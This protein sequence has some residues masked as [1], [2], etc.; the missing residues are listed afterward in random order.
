M[1]GNGRKIILK[2]PREIVYAHVNR[3]RIRSSNINLWYD[4]PGSIAIFPCSGSKLVYMHFLSTF[5]II[6]KLLM[7][8]KN[9][10]KYIL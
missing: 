7:Q 10:R 6:R 8:F 3:F 9:V 5:S 4:L 1:T 2:H